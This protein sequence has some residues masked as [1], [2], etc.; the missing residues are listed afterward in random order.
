[1][2]LILNMRFFGY[3]FIEYFSPIFDLSNYVYD[4]ANQ[5]A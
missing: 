2:H 1:M 4:K 3:P 5:S